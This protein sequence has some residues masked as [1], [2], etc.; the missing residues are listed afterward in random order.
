MVETERD[1]NVLLQLAMSPVESRDARVPGSLIRLAFDHQE[2][3][4]MVNAILSSITVTQGAFLTVH[5]V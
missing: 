5:L 1:P 4:W 2:L 3:L